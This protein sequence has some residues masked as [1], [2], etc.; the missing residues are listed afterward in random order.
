M[1]TDLQTTW[2]MPSIPPYL[3]GATP[4]AQPVDVLVVED[5]PATQKYLF[6]ILSGAGYRVRIASNGIRAIREVKEQVPHVI[7]IDL[8]MPLLDG[9]QTTSI[10]RVLEGDKHVPIIAT[11]ARRQKY[12]YERFVA[13][14]ADAFIEKPFAVQ[15]LL[16]LIGNIL[17][18]SPTPSPAHS[19]EGLH[20]DAAMTTPQLPIINIPASLDRLGGDQQLL[21]NLI[22]FFYE[23]FPGLLDE[24]RGAVRRHDWV[25]AHRAAHSLKGLVANFGAERCQSVLQEMELQSQIASPDPEFLTKILNDVEQEVS[26]LAAA[27]VEHH[28]QEGELGRK[29]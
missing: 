16:E 26:H 29:V 4:P 14:G 7:I 6:Q 17:K 19:A 25:R 27:L 11:T 28:P 10:L 20:E 9:L 23:D 15:S 8:Q 21:G 22:T 18:A 1:S 3:E 13:V 24:M 5:T 12:D 2:A